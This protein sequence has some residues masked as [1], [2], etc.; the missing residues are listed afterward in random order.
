[1][2]DIL[3]TRDIKFSYNTDM[4]ISFALDGITLNIK[5]GEY[6]GI[7]GHNGS[8]KSTLAKH[9]NAL[10][11]PME[12][13]V[14]VDGMDTRDETKTLEIRK[15]AG[16]VFQNPD[17]QLVA[18]VVEED[19]AFGPENLGVPQK[20][21]VER[22]HDALETVGMLEYAKRAPHMLSGGQKQRVTIAGTLALHPDMIIFDEPTAMLDPKGRADVLNTIRKLHDSGKTIVFITHY[23]E[24]VIDADRLIVMKDGKVILT[25]TPREV[26]SETELLETAGLVPPFACRL[27]SALKDCAE[28]DKNVLTTEE[29]VDEL[30]RLI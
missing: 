5:K 7:L 1:M 2:G 26:F 18:T 9:M 11:I 29:M 6:V 27:Q 19:V 20:E 23:M 10:L 8:G 13:V 22:V 4:D 28:F 24:E 15:T 17:N 30:C 25:G 21:I 3:K 12:G 14:E 16:M